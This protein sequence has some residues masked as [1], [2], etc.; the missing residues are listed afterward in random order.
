MAIDNLQTQIQRS[1][2]RPDE[3]NGILPVPPS[4]GFVVPRSASK[5]IDALVPI[6]LEKVDPVGLPLPGDMI[7]SRLDI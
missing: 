1:V 5:E 3:Q 6:G 2:V 4:D 7:G